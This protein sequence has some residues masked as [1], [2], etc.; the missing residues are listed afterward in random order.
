MEQQEGL[1]TGQNST[2]QDAVY[3]KRL[4]RNA[5]VKK[6]SILLALIIIPILVLYII[7]LITGKNY[8]SY[9][10]ILIFIII[11]LYMMKGMFRRK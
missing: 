5:T 8:M 7:E 11:H 6:Y 9:S 1:G 4:N 10:F 3:I 2:D